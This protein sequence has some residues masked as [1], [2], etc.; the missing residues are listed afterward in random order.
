MT[1]ILHTNCYSEKGLPPSWQVLSLQTGRGM[2]FMF[3]DFVCG[4]F[5]ACKDFMRMFDLL[6]LS[7]VFLF[8]V[9]ISS[10]TLIPLFV[11]GSVHS[12][13]AS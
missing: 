12:G 8:K 2:L 1:A 6:A 5:L 4:F 7:F 10:Q 11:P 3:T 13:S 9:E